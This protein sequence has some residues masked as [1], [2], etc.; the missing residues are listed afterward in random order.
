MSAFARTRASSLCDVRGH[1]QP[2][3]DLAR[4]L[5]NKLDLR[6]RRQSLVVGG[7]W[8]VGQGL[9][10]AELL[11]ELLSEV[12]GKGSEQKDVGLEHRTRPNRFGGEARDA[13]H[14]PG[15]AGIEP[16]LVEVVGDGPNGLVK[17]PRHS[18]GGRHVLHRAKKV[19]L[20]VEEESPAPLEP[21]S[22]AHHVPRGPGL[23]HLQGAHEHL[24]AT[25]GICA[26]L[27]D[28][29]VRVDHVASALGH[30]L[31]VLAE[32]ETLVDEP[33]E[34]LVRGHEAEIEEHLVPEPRVEEVEHGVLRAAHV[35][36]DGHPVALLR[37]IPERLRRSV[38]S[39]KRR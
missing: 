11:P 9:G 36:V 34:G 22:H 33:R 17:E 31:P 1:H 6:V 29:L 20:G 7:P 24:V 8:L 13:L 26:V 2:G 30:L 37:R 27:P 23:H 18:L 38:G 10:V 16:H 12:R 15:D 5:N 3:P 14:E 32:D 39:R 35:E 21:A 25:E 28:D 19:A 4:H